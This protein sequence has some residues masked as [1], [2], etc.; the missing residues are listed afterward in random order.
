MSSIYE[1]IKSNNESSEYDFDPRLALIDQGTSAWSIVKNAWVVGATS[2]QPVFAPCFR[3]SSKDLENRLMR[4][5]TGQSHTFNSPAMRH[6]VKYEDF[7]RDVFINDLY[8]KYGIKV[9]NNKVHE[10]GIISLK[11][12]E[13][14]I[15]SSLDGCFKDTEGNK[16]IVEI[17]CPYYN[18][19]YSTPDKFLKTEGYETSKCNSYFKKMPHEVQEFLNDST[20]NIGVYPPYYLQMQM[21]MAVSGIKYGFFTVCRI[22]NEDTYTNH[23]VKIEYVPDLFQNYLFPYLKKL[24]KNLHKLDIEMKDTFKDENMEKRSNQIFDLISKKTIVYDDTDFRCIKS[25]YSSPIVNF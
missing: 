1:T 20:D 10:S 14:T 11:D 24:I 3:S 18:P 21:Q 13:Y 15:G 22:I 23:I 2:V 9:E 25:L 4:K 17:K 12:Q 8:E 7:A 16:Y 5:F 6:G 19:K